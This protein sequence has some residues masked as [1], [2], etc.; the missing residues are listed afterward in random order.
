MKDIL[1]VSKYLLHDSA[2]GLM[3]FYGIII[4]IALFMIYIFTSVAN[5]ESGNVSFS[6]FGFSAAIFMF[7]AGLNSFKINFK[8]MQANNISRKRF[9]MA[10]AIAMITIAALMAA[11]DATITQILK[12][13]LPYNGLYEVLYKRDYFLG[14]VVWSFALFS[15]VGNLGWFIT[16]L[17][18]R[19][20]K[21]MKTVVSLAPVLLIFT[22]VFIDR[23]AMGAVSKGIFEFLP[24]ML[25][26]TNNNPY[27]AA[28]NF[29]LGAAG[30]V[31][32]SYVL[33]RRMAIRD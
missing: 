20:G 25:G 14:D 2:K 23:L 1:K 17:Y 9:Y 5:A 21:L 24:W 7:V 30:A 10:M 6:G 13:I 27:I 28:M 4:T 3:V 26:L 8:F 16:M 32:L 31:A 18:Y 29:F 19:C 12:L 15:F 11:T 22:L 33:I